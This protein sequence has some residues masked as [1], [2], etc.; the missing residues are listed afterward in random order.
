MNWFRKSLVKFAL[1]AAGFPG[2]SFSLT[3]GDAVSR[4]F[5]G[6]T[7]T[8]KTVDQ[9]SAMQITVV[10][11]CVRLLAETVGAMPL[12]VYR[13]SDNGNAEKV[14]HD[15]GKVLIDQPNRDMTGLE[16][17]ETCMSNLVLRG[18]AYS[19]IER[20]GNGNVAS[21]YPIPSARVTP[22]RNA[23]GL[24]YYE[25][26]EQGAIE[27]VPAEQIWHWRG[28]SFD[29]LCGL[30][31]LAT[32]R[33]AMGLALAGEEFNAKLFGQGLMP[34]A[35]VEIPTFLKKE[36]RTDAVA[37][38]QEMWAGMQNAGKPML[39]EGGMKVAEG[40]FPPEDAQFLQLRQ[41]TVE[42]LCRLFRISPHM[43][44]NLER[45]T[46]NNIERLSLEFVM[47]TVMPYLRRIEER[48]RQLLRPAD[49]S[50]YFLRFNFEGL[51]RA[52]SVARGQLYSILLQNGVYSRNEVRALENRNAVATDG[53]D[54]YTVQSNMAF[55]DALDQLTD[56]AAEPAV[57]PA[58][59]PA[60]QQQ[61]A[62][63]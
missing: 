48:A 39:L 50:R 25:V 7:H 31:P 23:Q 53:M 37:A 38:L 27:K 17:R 11:A 30:S 29:G 55:I 62:S 14:D 51:L 61:E 22:K 47:Y 10:W 57:D 6:R 24:V 12:A 56:P 33:E 18:N 40:L 58:A 54:D 34:S 63:A 13:K 4:Y 28:F 41:F 16:F 44:A 15:L 5:G 21:L 59:D 52:D 26:S 35:L 32:A 46:N 49:R 45:A 60:E 43:V 2:M 1:K 42:E 19:R 8:G 36:Q 3:D 9:S 20:S